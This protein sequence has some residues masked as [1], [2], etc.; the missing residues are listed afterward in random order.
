MTFFITVSV[1]RTSYKY[2]RI[3]FSVT[4]NRMGAKQTI[5]QSTYRSLNITVSLNH[6]FVSLAQP[7]IAIRIFYIN[8][9]IIFYIIY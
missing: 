8:Q 7:F 9:E 2:F 4:R 6:R 3:R 1:N 5:C